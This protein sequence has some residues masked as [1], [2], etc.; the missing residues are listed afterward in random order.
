MKKLVVVLLVLSLM[1]VGIAGAG[2]AGENPFLDED[3]DVREDVEVGDVKE[4]YILRE[5]GIGQL[6]ITPV[7]EKVEEEYKEN[8][9]DP[10]IQGAYSFFLPGL[11]MLGANNDRAF[12]H[13]GIGV[14]GAIATG[15]VSSQTTNNTVR[16]GANLAY[17]AFG[18]YSARASYREAED[19]NSRLL[20]ELE[21]TYL[22]FDSEGVRVGYNYNF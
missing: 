17:F 20:E 12:K 1:V 21:N 18:A 7:E 11:G 3:G 9:A 19:Y 16:L 2:I 10:F 5:D 4:G 6:Y 8:K 14:G 13:L 22:S 15:V